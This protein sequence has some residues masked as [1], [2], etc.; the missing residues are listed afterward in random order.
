MKLNRICLLL[1]IATLMV[2]C[3][4]I[5][6]AENNRTGIPVQSLSYEQAA[7]GPTGSIMTEGY[8]KAIANYA[9][10]WGWPMVNMHNR[11]EAFKQV[12]YQGYIGGAMPAAPINHLTMLSD[13]VSPNMRDVAHPNQDV[14]YG[15]GML[16][17]DK[18]PVVI[19][20]P[21]FGD[22]FWTVMA[23]DQRTD[24][25]AQLSS[26]YDSK[27]GF[28]MIVSPEWDGEI[29]E[30]I[31][32]VFRSSTDLAVVIPRVFMDDTAED[33]EAIQSVVNQLGAYPLSE[34]TGIMKITNWKSLP[35]IP[36]AKK[37]KS[38]KTWVNPNMFFSA[39][40]LGKVLE[41]VSPLPGEEAM[42]AQ[43]KELLLQAEENKELQKILND[44][45]NEAEMNIV[46]PLFRLENVGKEINNYWTRPQDN[47]RFG[48]DYLTRL[49]VAKSNIF[50]NDVTETSYLYQYKDE[51]GT[52]I[53]G[54][55]NYTLT[56]KKGELP[57][58]DGFWS[59][60]MYN[61][62][63]FFV[64]NDI[65]R[66]SI[67]TKNKG[68]KYNKD[69]SLTIYIQNEKPSEDKIGNWLPAPKDDI[70]MTI[71]AYGPKEE[72]LS[73]TWQPPA[74]VKIK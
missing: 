51:N 42:Y 66:Y 37:T 18:E 6:I 54:N 71:R 47:G 40:Q 55:H 58:V 43:F 17:L 1:P 52:R 73:G 65:K 62:N 31:N 46:T 36:E 72:M 34:F 23:E 60:T 57:P 8:A 12:P 53:N 48:T 4:N 39:E 5:S 15:F 7:K 74:V 26:I 10:V 30:G 49:A 56:F 14:V 68:M 32:K 25:F 67:G 2:G 24:S 70:A 61:S 64:P 59:L 45:A 11:R 9:Y 63:H 27:P 38:E 3:Q 28:Y 16:S 33:R 69:G 41:E 50:T 22:R 29:P 44:V 20:V 21:D 13:Y 19:Q 35:N